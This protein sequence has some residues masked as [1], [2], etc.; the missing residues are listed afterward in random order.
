MSV[1][2]LIQT[3]NE[4][5]SAREYENARR[6]FNEAV[7]HASSAFGEDS[8]Q[9]LKSLSYLASFEYE[10]G[11]Y[12][13]AIG[14]YEEAAAGYRKLPDCAEQLQTIL[15]NLG[16][17]YRHNGQIDKAKLCLKE[18]LKAASSVK[19]TIHQTAN[20]AELYLHTGQLDQAQRLLEKVLCEL[21][22]LNCEESK[23]SA[24]A[25]ANLAGVYHAR[26][27]SE[28]ANS[29]Y[30]NAERTIRSVA[31]E[32]SPLLPTILV[33]RAEVCIALGN[34]QEAEA[35][36]SQGLLLSEQRMDQDHPEH[37]TTLHDL[38]TLLNERGRQ[39]EAEALLRRALEI[40]RN[41]LGPNH[42]ETACT[43]NSLGT[44]YINAGLNEE[45][46][47][48][49]VQALEA[50]ESAKEDNYRAEVIRWNLFQLYR[51][52]GRHENA[53]EILCQ[54]PSGLISF[55]SSRSEDAP[56]PTVAE[57]SRFSRGERR[58]LTEEKASGRFETLDPKFIYVDQELSK[59]QYEQ[60]RFHETFHRTLSTATLSGILHLHLVKLA[61]SDSNSLTPAQRQTVINMA[62]HMFKQM[63]LVQEGGATARP[64][65]GRHILHLAFGDRTAS[66][67][68]KEDYLNTLDP[69][70]SPLFEAY[71]D[72]LRALLPTP[73][74]FDSSLLCNWL[75][76]AVARL[77]MNHPK[78]M[79][80]KYVLD[81]STTEF[82][83]QTNVSP[84]N[85]ML[86]LAKLFSENPDL[87]VTFE[88]RLW[89]WLTATLGVNPR[90]R[91]INSQNV[92]GSAIFRAATA[93]DDDEAELKVIDGLQHALLQTLPGYGINEV[94][95]IANAPLWLEQLE[96]NTANEVSGYE[97]VTFKLL[98]TSAEKIFALGTH[99]KPL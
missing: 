60:A 37:A 27:W 28:L 93:R 23:E 56:E 32:A 96:Q 53:A 62:N 88:D 41:K 89:E 57:L 25:A 83:S 12:S 17:A 14:A 30:L 36:L 85:R 91:G 73:G 47:S 94:E 75:S 81:S 38:G 78:L 54:L 77:V 86:E 16:A 10:Q 20:L 95:M 46:E 6:V 31:S 21:A 61:S 2:E 72:S 99:L 68:T 35:L 92:V 76:E 87:Q 43:L 50:V 24:T 84:S 69:K 65:F 58:A 15:N 55:F 45:A 7:S 59:L 42:L 19:D 29:M 79:D 49:Y 13:T 51:R 1:E 26:G 67:Q 9:H 82:L 74:L 71:H 22:S 8:I 97:P 33:N 40:R 63:E 98:K 34:H 3:A 48:H 64:Y 52:L 39:T 80:I 66:P 4:H 5:Y 11:Q 90:Q 70:Y 18:S 44:I